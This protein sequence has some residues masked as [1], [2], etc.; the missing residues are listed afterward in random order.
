[1]AVDSE[2]LEQRVQTLLIM[3]QFGREMAVEEL[4][5]ISNRLGKSWARERCIEGLKIQLKHKVAI[6]AAFF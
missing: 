1:M 3:E 4:N 2:K 6:Q 5:S